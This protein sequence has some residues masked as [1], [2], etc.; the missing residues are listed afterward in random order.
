MY[1]EFDL[2]KHHFQ[3]FQELH[4]IFM[5]YHFIIFACFKTFSPWSKNKEHTHF[6]IVSILLQSFFKTSWFIVRLIILMSRSLCSQSSRN[7]CW[8][9]AD[10]F[11]RIFVQKGAEKKGGAEPPDHWD[12]PP[13][14]RGFFELLKVYWQVIVRLLTGY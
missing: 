4:A 6:T 13:G 9:S 8:N 2:V 1:Y 14:G 3:R 7:I 11:W 12:A 5:S 10:T